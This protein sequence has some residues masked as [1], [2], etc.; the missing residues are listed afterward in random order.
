MLAEDTKRR[1]PI[2]SREELYEIAV[3][4]P[5]LNEETTIYTVVNDFRIYLPDAKICVY[6]NNSIDK[7]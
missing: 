7:T 2:N 1:L 3:L 4:I 6:D 5:C